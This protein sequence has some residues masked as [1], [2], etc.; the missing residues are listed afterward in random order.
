[1]N[2]LI[3]PASSLCNLRC[4]YCFY[5]DE[6]NSRQTQSFGMMSINTL[7][8]IVS[9]A[10][11][12]AGRECTFGF[13]GGE[14]TLA[15]LDFF[16]ELIRLQQKYNTRGIKI[17]NALQTNGILIDDEWAQFFADNGFLVGLSLDGNQEI[18]DRYRKDENRARNFQSGKT[19]CKDIGETRCAVQCAERSDIGIGKARQ[20]AYTDFS[21]TTALSISSIYHV[22]IRWRSQRKSIL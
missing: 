2:V 3:K 8:N 7:E 13:Q 20:R 5:H 12:A 14:P 18:H 9:K 16:R 19:G 1:M 6:A 21:C 22:W 10:L 15:R 17:N 11:A 4:G